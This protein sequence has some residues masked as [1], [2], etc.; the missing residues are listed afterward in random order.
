MR[1]FFA[2]R[3]GQFFTIELSRSPF[4]FK[5]KYLLPPP[6]RKKNRPGKNFRRIFCVSSPE[7]NK[8]ALF[9]GNP[10]ELSLTPQQ[11]RGKNSL[12]ALELFR[13]FR[14]RDRITEKISL[15]LIK[16]TARTKH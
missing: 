9:D 10:A 14:G 15:L 3:R 5:V 6:A 11:L 8:T 12:A 2:S 16:A 4:E 13:V 1:A 7:N